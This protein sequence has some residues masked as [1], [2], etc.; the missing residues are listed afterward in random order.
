MDSKNPPHDQTHAFCKVNS[1]HVVFIIVRT[2]G[3]GD[4]M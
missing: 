2:I 3:A 4:V 1:T